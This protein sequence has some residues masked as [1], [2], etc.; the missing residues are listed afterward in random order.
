LAEIG[1][2][3]I[4]GV[5]FMKKRMIILS[6]LL[7]LLLTSVVWWFVTTRMDTD[8]ATKAF[9]EF[10]YEAVTGGYNPSASISVVITEENDISALKEILRGRTLRERLSC[11]FSPHISITMSDGRQSITLLP[12]NGGCPV[13]RIVDSNRGYSNRYIR[14]TVEAIAK[15]HEIFERHGGFFPCI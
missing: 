4:V 1:V 3:V 15:L 7:I 10:H 13:L 9:L 6:I 11:G 5:E 8:F 14:V 12:A 2:Q